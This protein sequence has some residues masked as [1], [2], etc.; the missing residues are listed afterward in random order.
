[1]PQPK[2]YFSCEEKKEARRKTSARHYEKHKEEIAFR[3]QMKRSEQA[4]KKKQRKLEK[5]GGNSDLESND[6]PH[7][8]QGKLA[9]PGRSKQNQKP[10]I[11]TPQLWAAKA[12]QLKAKIDRIYGE[13]KCYK[14][15]LK[16]V[17]IQFIQDEK[18]E[19]IDCLHTEFE[20]YCSDFDKF[21]LMTIE[22]RGSSVEVEFIG[23]LRADTW[24]MLSGLT[25]IFGE[26]AMGVDRLALHSR[27]GRFSF[28]HG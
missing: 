7:K 24:L 10:P 9:V 5:Y 12:R 25:D 3:R 15:F 4:R 17:I 14:I 26:A 11:N 8:S 13:S 16:S 21:R 28:Q 18:L 27:K 22:C 20:H 19:R 23:N 2:L 6:T 1:M